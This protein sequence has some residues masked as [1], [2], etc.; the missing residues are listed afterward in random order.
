[1]TIGA[2]WLAH[3]ALTDRLERTDSLFVRVN[4]LV[5]MV[6][7]FLP[8]PTRLVADALHGADSERVAVTLYGLTLLAIRL[9]ASALDAYAR[10]EHLYKAQGEGTELQREE[11]EF[12]PVIVV[13][14]IAILIGLVLPLVSVA[15]YFAIAVFMVVPFR[16][17]SRLLFRRA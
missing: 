16:A 7:A 12:L 11:R 9:L 5:L 14:V 1:M 4:L 17:I 2:A 6:I 8:F 10:R 3:G 13:Y 15:L